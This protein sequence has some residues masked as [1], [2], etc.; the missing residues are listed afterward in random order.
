MHLQ[1]LNVLYHP[2]ELVVNN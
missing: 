2:M 1:S